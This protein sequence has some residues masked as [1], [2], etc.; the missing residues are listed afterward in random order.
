MLGQTELALNGQ[1]VTMGVNHHVEKTVSVGRAT[2]DRQFQIVWSAPRPIAGDPWAADNII[3]DARAANAQRDV[4]DALP[5]PL[6]VFDEQ[7]NVCYS[8]ASAKAHFGDTISPNILQQLR[9]TLSQSGPAE[10]RVARLPEITAQNASGGDLRMTVAASR[11]VFAGQPAHLLSLSDIT[12]I[13]NIEDQ[14]RARNRQLHELS[15][16]DPL[17]G[18]N[19]RRHFVAA[20][21]AGLKQMHRQTLPASMFLLDLDHF[22]VLNDRYGH[23]FGDHALVEVAGAARRMMRKNDVF[24]R[25]GGE[26][27]AGFLPETDIGDGVVIV[28]RLRKAVGQVQL[29]AGND[30]VGVTCSIGIALVDPQ[31]DTP[32]TA[33]NRADQALYAAKRQGRD[34]VH[35][36]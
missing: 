5:S 12:Y 3:A 14:L 25:V 15:I 18:V 27:F 17:T 22:K 6:I 36:H 35:W 11:M 1:T 23:E 13:R 28:E 34:R 24:A 29:H 30:V 26:E 9:A 16:T 21:G 4:L 20:V 32:E 19:N 7:G 2:R 31:A 33:M 10:A 8:S